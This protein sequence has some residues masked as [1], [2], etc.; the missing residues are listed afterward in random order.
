MP[1]CVVAVVAVGTPVEVAPAGTSVCVAAAAE[2]VAG[3]IVF[4]AVVA[5]GLSPLPRRN[6]NAAPPTTRSS[7]TTIAIMTTG[8]FPFFGSSQ[9]TAAAGAGADATIIAGAGTAAGAP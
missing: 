5:T 3:A 1:V 7:P 8:D 6:T 9:A 4:D 2:V